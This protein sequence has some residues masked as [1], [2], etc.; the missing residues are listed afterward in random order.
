MLDRT[1][2]ETLAPKPLHPRLG[3]AL[4]LGLAA[5]V[6][7]VRFTGPADWSDGYHQERAIAYALNCQGAELPNFDERD[8]EDD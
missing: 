6:F 8:D 2:S 7:L 3:L 1:P 4:V 5:L